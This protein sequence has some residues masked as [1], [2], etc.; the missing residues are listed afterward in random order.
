M[1]NNIK[2]IILFSIYFCVLII[3]PNFYLI[4]GCWAW[5]AYYCFK[6]LAVGICL[7]IIVF[8]FSK[9]LNAYNNT[10]IVLAIIIITGMLYM[11]LNKGYKIKINNTLKFGTI[12][13]VLIILN[14]I[15]NG[16]T[17]INL[18]ILLIMA[19][20]VFVYIDILSYNN[21]IKEIKRYL[22]LAMI[23]PGIIIIIDMLPSIINN[24]IGYSRLSIDGNARV[25]A[26]PL[27]VASVV[28]LFKIIQGDKRIVFYLIGL[29]INMIFIV[30]TGSRGVLVSLLAVV[31]IYMMLKMSKRLILIICTTGVFVYY[32]SFNYINDVF[33]VQRLTNLDNSARNMI[34]SNALKTMDA[35]DI[36]LGAGVG[37]FKQQYILTYGQAV[38]AH[39]VFIDTLFSLGVLTTFILI[40][41]IIWISLQ[42]IKNKNL[43]GLIFLM[44]VVILFIPH[45][46]VQDIY[47]WVYL[48]IAQVFCTYSIKVDK[49]NK[50]HDKQ[51]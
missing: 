18:Y 4:L 37:E 23:I 25:L 2:S 39:S 29:I 24:S 40:I 44:F 12:L 19:I 8:P 49:L 30:M 50:C 38:Y 32:I 47:F 17:N 48:A 26:N 16:F 42:S 51:N 5:I 1:E 20:I 15:K 46:N 27:A 31:I 45:G 41:Y 7:A 43:N 13:I 10:L 3:N 34:W 6:N 9:I 28:L 35:G 21:K 36:I 22:E 14:F 33:N 11:L